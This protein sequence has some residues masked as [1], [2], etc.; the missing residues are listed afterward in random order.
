MPVTFHRSGREIF[1]FILLFLGIAFYFY[2]SPRYRLLPG[3]IG[4]IK[5][6]NPMIVVLEDFLLE[7]EAEILIRE[8]VDLLER[9]TVR[10][11]NDRLLSSQRT[12]RTAM[13]EYEKNLDVIDLIKKRA[14]KI[15]NIPIENIEPLQLV[16]YGVGE[17]YKPHYDFFSEDILNAS[18]KG[19]G[20][21]QVTFFVYLNSLDEGSGGG[22]VFPKVN[23]KVPPKKNTAVLFFDTKN[24]QV[25][26]N[27]LHG[28]APVLKGEKWG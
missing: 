23:V 26:Y 7:G 18:E 17:Q 21:R 19:K 16:H 10:G 22:T 11:V 5:S 13:L 24:N 12:S 3:M 27:T 20:Q 9:S 25:D 4:S 1:L 28:G 6:V 14:A 8:G 2:E 15:V